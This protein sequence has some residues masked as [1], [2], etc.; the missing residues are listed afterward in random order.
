MNIVNLT[1]L[2]RIRQPKR[3]QPG[4]IHFKRNKAKIIV[5]LHTEK[6]II[7]PHTV[8]AHQLVLFNK[9]QNR[10]LAPEVQQTK[11]TNS[12]QGPHH[13]RAQQA[14]VVQCQQQSEPNRILTPILTLNNNQN[15][16]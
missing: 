6:K 9:C 14:L 7:Q 12:N 1:T 11:V 15:G 8:K 10:L 4:K 5:R 16:R 13:R 3:V 2:I